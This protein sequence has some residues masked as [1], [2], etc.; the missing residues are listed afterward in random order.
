MNAHILL[1]LLNKLG[2]R[3]KI[4]GIPRN[5]NLFFCCSKLN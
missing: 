5:F 2:K 3:D 4:G 1:D